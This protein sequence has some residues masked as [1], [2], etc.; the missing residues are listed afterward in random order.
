MRVREG[1]SFMPKFGVVE[2]CRCCDTYYAAW[3][4]VRWFLCDVLGMVSVKCMF[5][6]QL[7]DI[8]L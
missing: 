7:G 1:D 6:V 8:K 5:F 3:V 4:V 2:E